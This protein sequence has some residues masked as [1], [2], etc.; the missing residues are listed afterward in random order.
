MGLE[1]GVIDLGLDINKK[2]FE[3]QLNN[4]ASG[5]SSAVSNAFSGLGKIAGA[6]FGFVAGAKVGDFFS[7]CLDQASDLAEVQNVVDVTFTEMSDTINKFAENAMDKFG[8]SE[9]AAKQMAGTMGAMLKS[10]GLT[11][12][13]AATMSTTLTALSGDLASFY[14]LSAEEAFSKVRAGISGETEGLKQLGINMSVANLEAYALTQGITKSYDAMSQAEQAILRYNYLLSVTG[15]QQGDFARTSDSFANQTKLLSMRFDELKASIGAGLIPIL[16]VAL[17]FINKLLSGLG[18]AVNFVKGLFGLGTG[19]GG[20]TSEPTIKVGV[21]TSPVTNG[22]EQL[23]APTKDLVSPISSVSKDLGKAGNDS[24]KVADNLKKATGNANKFKSTISGFD[25]I[26]KLS[27][28]SGLSG[29]GSGLDGIGSSLGGLNSAVDSI[30]AFNTGLNDAYGGLNNLIDAVN[31]AD[32]DL[33][34]SFGNVNL[35]MEQVKKVAKQIVDQKDLEKI[36]QLSNEINTLE[37]MKKNLEEVRDKINTYQW[38]ISMGIELTPDE[39]QDYKQSVMDYCQMV[40]DF[41][42]QKGVV[43][44]IAYDLIYGENSAEGNNASSFYSKME[45]QAKELT[46]KIKKCF[47][48]AFDEQGNIINIDAA[49]EYDNYVSQLNKLEEKIGN[50]DYKVAINKISVKASG[51]EL[52]QESFEALMKEMTDTVQTKL[53]GYDMALAEIKADLDL[54]LEYGKANGGIDQDEYNKKWLDAQLETEQK[55]IDA[56]KDI[57]DFAIET[58][59]NFFTRDEDLDDAI[60]DLNDLI[61]KQ[62]EGL[63]FSENWIDWQVGLDGLVDAMDQELENASPEMRRI[64]KELVQTL[65]VDS[66]TLQEV[67]N[68]HKAAGEKI[69]AELS[70]QLTNVTVLEALSGDTRAMLTLIGNQL[71][72]TQYEAMILKA[73]ESGAD[74]PKELLNGLNMEK[75]NINGGISTMFNDA[76]NSLKNYD[77]KAINQAKT[78]G[79]NTVDAYK[80]RLT[81]QESRSGIDSSINKMYSNAKDTINANK[82]A[83]NAM[84]SSANTA[85]KSFWSNIASSSNLNSTKTNTAKIGTAARNSIISKLSIS[86]SKS[87]TF[88]TYGKYTV[89]GFN[90][91]IS[92]NASSTS[93][94]NGPIANWV[95]S[96]TVYTKKLMDMHSPSKLFEGFGVFTV[97][98]FNNGIYDEM[99]STKDAFGEWLGIAQDF[100]DEISGV[101]MGLSSVPELKA[102]ALKYMESVKVE[103]DKEDATAISLND[104]LSKVSVII[105][106]LTDI[107]NKEINLDGKA[108]TDSVVKNNNKIYRQ[109]GRSPL[110]V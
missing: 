71:K 64:A 61:K 58:A 77:N 62:M 9:L 10:S 78:S 25:E 87:S 15:D 11:E 7:D 69:P 104:L 26:N 29:L 8:L 57:L 35:N 18:T 53:D 3:S 54:R 107:S 88:A 98:G 99:D 34:S 85:A 106:T 94:S 17:G 32:D 76:V 38:M 101:E 31:T 60:K 21:D 65:G 110:L 82:T 27:D 28:T 63:E 56:R 39:F 51:A 4:I 80:D 96:F 42:K 75:I 48:K 95:K 70:K 49:K 14:N 6:A 13:A 30:G 81:S 59:V 92:S 52:T 37:T 22:I 20:S 5:A 47:D 73:K 19:G 50:Y 66:A 91:G 83:S 1:V 97:Q 67:V 2:S 24:K 43:V 33:S 46:A 12:Q 105:D 44:E 74:V 109:T 55:K 108:I 103:S 93:A 89:Q 45:Q 36:G 68:Q 23:I 72:G 90:K 86:G 40:Q 41:I 79:S 16:N 84:K 102:P 100:G